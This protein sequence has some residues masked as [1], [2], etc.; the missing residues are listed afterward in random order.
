VRYGGSD[1]APVTTDGPH[2]ETSDLLAGWWMIDVDSHERA[3]ELDG[4]LPAAATA[5]VEA[6][7]RA[8]NVAERD[9]LVRQA[10]RARAVEL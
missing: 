8:T 9:H 2:P 5:Y 3:V 6:A 4:E 1:A 10:A 7:R